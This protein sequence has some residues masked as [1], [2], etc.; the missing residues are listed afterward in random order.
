MILFNCKKTFNCDS[1]SDLV[2]FT[3]AQLAI[4]YLG[5]VKGMVLLCKRRVILVFYCLVIQC[6]ILV[7]SVWLYFIFFIV[8]VTEVFERPC[9]ENS[10]Q[11]VVLLLFQP[12]KCT[13]CVPC[14]CVP[15][16]RLHENVYAF[17][18]SGIH[19]EC[20][21]EPCWRFLLH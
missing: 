9:G 20:L 3:L 18:R 16:W 6:I 5:Y 15:T 8:F 1:C 21:Q 19:V 14:C 7:C 17:F 10:S 4:F 11:Y 2:P 12:Y 13:A